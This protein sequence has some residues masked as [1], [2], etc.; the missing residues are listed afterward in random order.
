LVLGGLR[1]ELS[2]RHSTGA[3]LAPEVVAGGLKV[4]FRAGGERLRAGT[5]RHHRTLKYLFQS[6]GIFPWMR[7]HV[8]LVF[9][10]GRLAAVADLW[11]AGWAAAAPAQT[12]LQVVWTLHAPIQ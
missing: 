4:T 3:G 8:P 1:G 6:R 7:C 12:G 2:L 11:T 5:D 10:R 9:A